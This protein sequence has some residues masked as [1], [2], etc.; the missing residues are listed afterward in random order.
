MEYDTP[1]GLG[2]G[3]IISHNQWVSKTLARRT[4]DLT[5][6]YDCMGSSLGKFPV[7]HGVLLAGYTT[8]QG[9]VPWTPAQFASHPSAIRIDQSPQNTPADELCDVL[10][11]EQQAATIAD[12]PGWV[13]AALRNWVTIAR[14]GQR[15]P[16][17]YCSHS[18]LTPVANA[19]NAAGITSG[20][21][22]W[23][24]EPMTAAMARTE[25]Q[26]AGGPFPVIGVQYLFMGDHDVSIFNT[27]W[28]NNVSRKTPVP[29]P[30]VGTQSGWAYCSKCTGLFFG[31]QEAQSHCPAGGH[32]DGSHSHS[33]NLPFIA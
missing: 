10:D 24:A 14:P 15:L 19:L 32:H 22:I 33:Y 21:D 26:K 6:V 17:V 25:L 20:V 4:V 30:G 8:G 31:P 5:T 11:V 1:W 18:T 28:L 27:A 16:A 3:E 29:H 13:R 12:T 7:P 2:N 9:G 23:L